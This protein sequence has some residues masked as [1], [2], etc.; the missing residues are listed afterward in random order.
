[1]LPKEV[2]LGTIL[3]VVTRGWWKFRY[4]TDIAAQARIKRR[5]ACRIKTIRQLLESCIY[6]KE[7]GSISSFR[8]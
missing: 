1:M 2:V 7:E 5:S 8:S 3:A 6:S 4:A